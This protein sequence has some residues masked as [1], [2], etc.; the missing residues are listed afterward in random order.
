MSIMRLLKL[1]YM[2]HGWNLAAIDKPLVN[3]FVQAWQHGPVV[4]SIHYA[5]RPQGV[6]NLEQI[7]LVPELQANKMKSEV[8][9]LLVHVFKM[10]Q[11]YSDRQLSALTHIRNGPWHRT[12]RNG[13]RGIKI[14]NEL[15]KEHFKSK[16]E[17]SRQT[18]KDEPS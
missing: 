16:L 4:P 11:K 7:Q 5:Y 15:I 13:V 6:Y 3:D 10:Y 12:Y 9:D 17:R 18:K 14:A 2:S 1:T 8:D